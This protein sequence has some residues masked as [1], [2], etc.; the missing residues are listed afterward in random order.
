MSG[1]V[2]SSPLQV[3]LAHVNNAALDALAHPSTVFP[4]EKRRQESLPGHFFLDVNAQLLRASRWSPVWSRTANPAPV[5]TQRCVIQQMAASQRQLFN[6]QI[7][8]YSS[9][10]QV[11]EEGEATLSNDGQHPSHVHCW[12]ENNPTICV[13]CG[14]GCGMWFRATSRKTCRRLPTEVV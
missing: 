10:H 11:H 6:S 1:G 9:Q 2:S 8:S 12:R 4:G 5:P 13:F 14:C 7:L 3:V